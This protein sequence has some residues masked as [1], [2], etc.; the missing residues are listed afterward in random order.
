ML[1]NYYS[2]FIARRL[3]AQ[4]ALSTGRVNYSGQT[5]YR[6]I[7]IDENKTA[8]QGTRARLLW[9]CRVNMVNW[10]HDKMTTLTPHWTQGTDR[11]EGVSLSPG[12]GCEFIGLVGLHDDDNLAIVDTSSKSL[13]ETRGRSFYSLANNSWLAPARDQHSSLHD[14]LPH[15]VL[16]AN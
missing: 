6:P 4:N 2:N 15:P 1:E 10:P 3:Y 16:T 9:K 8:A 7:E 14:L 13:H 11:G 12:W 5:K